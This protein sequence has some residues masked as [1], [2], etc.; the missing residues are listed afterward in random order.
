MKTVGAGCAVP[1]H[2]GGNTV[3]FDELQTDARA[4]DY[5][6]KI[7]CLAQRGARF[8]IPKL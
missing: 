5:R 4:D 7:V 2:F 3:I 6:D 8:F 1:M